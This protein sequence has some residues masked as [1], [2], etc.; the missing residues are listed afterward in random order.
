MTLTIRMLGIRATVEF[1]ELDGEL[2]IESIRTSDD[3]TDLLTRDQ[4]A[5]V[6]R[7]IAKEKNAVKS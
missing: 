1:F 4:I 7:A 6:E 2:R 3:I 5:Q